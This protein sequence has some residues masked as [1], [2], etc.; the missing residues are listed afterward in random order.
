M[1]G[2]TARAQSLRRLQITRAAGR[3]GCREAVCLWKAAAGA[4]QLRWLP[5]VAA[6][7]QSGPVLLTHAA[8]APVPAH[9]P[10]LASRHLHLG[11]WLASRA[12]E[13]P[14]SFRRTEPARL[15]AASGGLPGV[16]RAPTQP[17]CLR[18]CSS[19]RAI[20][21]F[22]KSCRCPKGRAAGLEKCWVRVVFL[23]LESGGG[24]SS[25][26]SPAA[27]QVQGPCPAQPTSPAA[28]RLGCQWHA[29]C[30]AG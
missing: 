4:G 2:C 11:G 15:A 17:S 30:H 5:P 9:T 20:C 8:A 1:G 13:P 18:A 7:Q 24:Q 19:S 23:Q 10:A 3:L 12:C 16:G 29:R 27:F 26:C 22:M 21:V 25:L 14:E 28:A 6:F